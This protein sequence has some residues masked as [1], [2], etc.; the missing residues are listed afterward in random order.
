MPLFYR[1]FLINLIFF[2]V[3]PCV[4]C[5]RCFERSI[6]EEDED[7][8]LQDF[9]GRGDDERD[10]LLQQHGLLKGARVVQKQVPL[11]TTSIAT[12]TTSADEEDVLGDGWDSAGGGGAGNRKQLH[13]EEIATTDDDELSKLLAGMQ[14]EAEEVQQTAK[15]GARR[16]GGRP[17][18]NNTE[19]EDNDTRFV[20]DVMNQSRKSLQTLSSSSE[21]FFETRQSRSSSLSHRIESHEDEQQQQMIANELVQSL[22]QAKI[23]YRRLDHACGQVLMQDGQPYS[24]Q[25]YFIAIDQRRYQFFTHAV[26]RQFWVAHRDEEVGGWL[27]RCFI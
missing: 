1:R 8:S 2:L 26:L 9:Q 3:Y 11:S 6:N 16:S 5:C 13:S 20:L 18:Y 4:L 21:I 17:Y 25:G 14:S 10:R 27:L 24:I 12:T 22:I 15:E 19:D 23:V 7:G